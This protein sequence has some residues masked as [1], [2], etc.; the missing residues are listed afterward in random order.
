MPPNGAVFGARKASNRPIGR[1]IGMMAG[2]ASVSASVTVT[3]S[4][5][6]ADF[7]SDAASDPVTDA[8]AATDAVTVSV[9]DSDS[10]TDADADAAPDAAPDSVSL[11]LLVHRDADRRPGVP[12]SHEQRGRAWE[13]GRSATTLL[14][15]RRPPSE[16]EEPYRNALPVECPVAPL[17]GMR[18]VSGWSY[19]HNSVPGTSR[20]RMFPT[21][22][23]AAPE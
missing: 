3:V 10:D 15:R 2:D 9:S 4:V 1:Q 13:A 22:P 14:A 7:D 16:P 5:A 12:A 23:G 6:V 17:C 18:C 19:R 8:D 21:C 11:G 20:W